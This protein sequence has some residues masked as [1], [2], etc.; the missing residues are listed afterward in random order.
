LEGSF[1]VRARSWRRFQNAAP[2]PTAE[3]KTGS[4]P[5]ISTINTTFDGGIPTFLRFS[6]RKCEGLRKWSNADI[7]SRTGV[8]WAQLPDPERVEAEAAWRRVSGRAFRARPRLRR[9]PKAEH[10]YRSQACDHYLIVPFSASVAG[11]PV[12]VYR[13]AIA[14]YECR[15]PLIALGMFC[16]AEFF[17][18]PPDL[19]WT[20]IH[21]HEDHAIEGPYFILADWIPAGS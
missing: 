21:T 9:G 8:E 5:K 4:K 13:Q 12:H 7:L 20:M 16:D 17:I 15:G 1:V 14:A 6:A 10:E 2:G 18:S 11:L 3:I 19:T